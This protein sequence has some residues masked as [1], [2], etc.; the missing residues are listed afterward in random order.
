MDIGIPSL[1]WNWLQNVTSGILGW[2]KE[3]ECKWCDGMKRKPVTMVTQEG[4][5]PI[6]GMIG[7]PPNKREMDVAEAPRDCCAA[8]TMSG[9]PSSVSFMAARERW[10][11]ETNVKTL[12]SETTETASA[13]GHW[14]S[15]ME[16]TVRQQGREV[17]Q[18]HE[19]IDR[20]AWILEAHEPCEETQWICMNTWL[21]DREKQWDD[22]H[23]DNI[24]WVMGITDMTP[25]VS[26]NARVGEAAPAE[27]GRKEERDE[28]AKQDSRGLETS[29]HAGATQDGEPEKCQLQQQAKLKPKPKLQHKQQPE[30]QHQPNSMP[31]PNPARRWKTV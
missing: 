15:Q 19:T 4:N 13:P 29:Q 18:L 17:T 9:N 25:E 27:E 28:T 21:E 6:G 10:E 14:R 8:G 24:L 16:R 23:N 31:T 12:R 30:P 2:S 5:S 26:A 7:N 3:A 22:R 20:M 11:R 1:Q